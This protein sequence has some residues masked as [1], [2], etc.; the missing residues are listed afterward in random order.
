M[1][2]CLRDQGLPRPSAPSFALK[3]DSEAVICITPLRVQSQGTCHFLSMLPVCSGVRNSL[4]V[5]PHN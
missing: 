5:C 4:M 3:K 1:A 2:S